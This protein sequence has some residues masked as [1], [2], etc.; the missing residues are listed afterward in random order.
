MGWV[1]EE[2]HPVYASFFC[3]KGDRRV[4]VQLQPTLPRNPLLE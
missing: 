3:R 1:L 4:F 2:E